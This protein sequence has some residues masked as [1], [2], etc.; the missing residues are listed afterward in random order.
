MN[1]QR[2]FSLLEVLVAFSVMALSLGVL[3]QIFSSSLRGAT[4]VEH[5]SRGLIIA[6]SL[7]AGVGAEI[8]LETSNLSGETEDVYHWQMDIQE[9]EMDDDNE[10]NRAILYQV[11]LQLGWGKSDHVGIRLDTL[12]LGLRE[13]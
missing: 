7:M 4:A 11:K 9:F 8:P 10:N 12:R 5:Y 3:M 6:E 13:L 1:R 2:G